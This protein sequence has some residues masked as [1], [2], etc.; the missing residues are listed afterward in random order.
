ME[1][2]GQMESNILILLG[3]L[4]KVISHSLSEKLDYDPYVNFVALKPG[5][6]CVK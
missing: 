5:L 6:Y 1:N 4:E 3:I 2:K